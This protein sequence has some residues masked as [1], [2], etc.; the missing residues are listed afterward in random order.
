LL[1]AAGLTFQS[2]WVFARALEVRPLPVA[3]D[4]WVA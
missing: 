3:P 1:A 4:Q 2:A